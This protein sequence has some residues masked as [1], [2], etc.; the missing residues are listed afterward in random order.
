MTT[1]DLLIA[2]LIRCGMGRLA[3]FWSR[4]APCPPCCTGC[5]L[6]YPKPRRLRLRRRPRPRPRV[7][8]RRRSSVRASRRPKRPPPPSERNGALSS[9]RMRS[10]A[11]D[12]AS[13]AW[14]IRAMSR[15]RRR[16]QAP[17]SEACFVGSWAR[18]RG[19]RGNCWC[20]QR[21]GR[22]EASLKVVHLSRGKGNQANAS[23]QHHSG[24]HNI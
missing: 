12:S 9:A 16:V 18:R 10:C 1:D 23:S 17:P 20:R 13:R 19:G 3:P 8:A 21:R 5:A 11:R 2:S 14:P 15:A 22:V 24:S 7:R 4:T 6:R